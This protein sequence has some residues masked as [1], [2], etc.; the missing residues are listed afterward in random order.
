MFNGCVCLIFIGLKI[1]YIPVYILFKFVKMN[2]YTWT[3]KN[4]SQKR[5]KVAITS[6]SFYLKEYRFFI[7]IYP[8]GDGVGRNTHLSAFFVLTQGENDE[9]LQWPF[10]AVVQLSLLNCL[11]EVVCY[12][13]IKTDSRSPS[14]LKPV[15]DNIATGS[16]K[17]INLYSLDSLLSVNDD[18]LII[19]F[20]ILEMLPPKVDPPTQDDMVQSAKK[21]YNEMQYLQ[22]KQETVMN[23]L[24]KVLDKML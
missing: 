11:G 5:H 4:F 24:K 22:K 12:D 23:A 7:K 6:D 9:Q 18:T 20:E 21:L 19:K 3:I 8:T 16:P 14:F 2:S 15:E 13:K 17:F 1:I 10:S